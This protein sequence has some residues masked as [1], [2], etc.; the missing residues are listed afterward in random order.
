MKRRPRESRACF[1]SRT[2]CPAASTDEKRWRWQGSKK[3]PMPS[4][5]HLLGLVGLLHGLQSGT[6]RLAAQ[7]SPQLRA[8][9][10]FS[11]APS[12]GRPGVRADT[13]ISKRSS[14]HTRCPPWTWLCQELQ[15]PEMRREREREN[16]KQTVR[17]KTVSKMP[18][19]QLS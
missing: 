4:L 19:A 12:P 7:G 18:W 13:C 16:K 9:P 2:C 1:G 17:E 11:F 8:A 14:E 5:Q 15:R 6:R 3:A 10:S